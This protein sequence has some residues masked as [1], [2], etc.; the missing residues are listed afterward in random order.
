[1]FINNVSYIKFFEKV[2]ETMIKYPENIVAL[3]VFKMKSVH[4]HALI[5]AIKITFLVHN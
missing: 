3:N 5:L 1:M 4:V 2:L